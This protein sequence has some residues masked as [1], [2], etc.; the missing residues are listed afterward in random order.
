MMTET[1]ASQAMHIAQEAKAAVA[2]HEAIC[3]ERYKSI[4]DS[5][6]RIEASLLAMSLKQSA[7]VTGIYNRFWMI[8]AGLFACMFAV[9]MALVFKP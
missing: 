3:A 9:G 8:A 6:K 4:A 5:S 1:V 7:D 2:S